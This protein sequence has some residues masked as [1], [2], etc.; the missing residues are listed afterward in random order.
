MNIAIGPNNRL[1]FNNDIVYSTSYSLQPCITIQS[2][3]SSH[4]SE[5]MCNQH[6][7]QGL[8]YLRSLSYYYAGNAKLC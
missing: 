4:Q 3:S 2:D 7:D 5:D 1:V 8:Q 6:K